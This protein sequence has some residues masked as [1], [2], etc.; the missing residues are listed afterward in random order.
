MGKSIKLSNGY[1]WDMSS[2]NFLYRTWINGENMDFD[3]CNKTGIYEYHG[4]IGKYQP[5]IIAYYDFGILIVFK[6]ETYRLQILFVG[7]NNTLL[8]RFNERDW[9]VISKV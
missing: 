9:N 6:T 4:Y 8:Y 2:T 7:S 5:D 3:D 1:V